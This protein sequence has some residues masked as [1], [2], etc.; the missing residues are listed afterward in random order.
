[1]TPR[2][3]IPLLLAL[4]AC[5]IDRGT[6]PAAQPQRSALSQCYVD[7]HHPGTPSCVQPMFIVDGK[8]LVDGA[9]DLN[10]SDIESV[11]VYKGAKAV[12]IYGED[13]RNGVVVITSRKTRATNK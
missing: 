1:M 4:T 8:R 11:E 2:I 6:S 10:P 7:G 12:E 5:S 9:A 13:A 3:A